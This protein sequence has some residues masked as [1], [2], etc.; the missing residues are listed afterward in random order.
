MRASGRSISLR[1]APAECALVQGE[2]FPAARYRN[3]A[4]QEAYCMSLVE[5]ESTPARVAASQA[6]GKK[7]NGPSTPEGKARVSLNALKTGAY[8]K[9]DRARR[10]VM[11]RRGENPDDFEQLHQELTEDW[12]PGYVTEAMLV[13]TIAEKSFD[14]AQL[15][16]AWTESGTSPSE[17]PE[18]T[19]GVASPGQSAVA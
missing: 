3:G 13:K 2:S 18:T 7:S 15:R 9:S 4:A 10:E 19:S 8:A 12:Q 14:K 1:L 16:A 5:R 17:P 6:N 11:L